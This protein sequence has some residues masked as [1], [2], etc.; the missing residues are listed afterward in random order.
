MKRSVV[1]VS[2]SFATLPKDQLNSFAILVIVCL[3]KSST[4]FPNLPITIAALTLLQ[5]AYGA[6]ITAAA[7]G[8]NKET[9]DLAEARGNLVAALRQIASYIQSIPGITESQVLTSG[10]DVVVWSKNKITLVAPD[11]ISLDNSIS[12]QLGVYLQAVS[13]A[14]AYHV[15]Y[16]TGTGAWLDVGIW[17]NT[18]GIVILNLTPGTVYSVRICG[19]GGSTQYGPWS[20]TVSLM[21]I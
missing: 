13:G 10:F 19:I 4:L 1:R 9:A 20:A 5:T 2:L 8:G 21:C 11:G 17:P 12:A 18:K 16:C 14:K 3:T 15:Q 6:A 7:V